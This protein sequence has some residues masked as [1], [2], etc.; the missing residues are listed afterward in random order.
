[1]TS[2]VLVP[3][4]F[5]STRSGLFRMAGRGERAVS[6]LLPQGAEGGHVGRQYGNFHLRRRHD[7]DVADLPE[8]IISHS[9]PVDDD[10][11]ETRDENRGA[12]GCDDC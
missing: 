2:R 6:E 7:A 11:P 1:M 8:E 5:V 4:E 9:E 12:T 3:R 10:E